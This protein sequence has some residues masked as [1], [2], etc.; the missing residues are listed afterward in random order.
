[1]NQL[2]GRQILLY[3]N[4]LNLFWSFV[5][6]LLPISLNLFFPIVSA[7]IPLVSA[8]NVL[9]TNA[10]IHLQLTHKLH[11]DLRGTQSSVCPLTTCLY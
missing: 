8:L 7:L 2:D 9:N 10:H 4:A 3:I 6:G 11:P 1:M 5:L